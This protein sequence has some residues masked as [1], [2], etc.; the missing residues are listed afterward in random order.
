MFRGF[1]SYKL[2][3][4]SHK[5]TMA[6][7]VE[8]L[9]GLPLI[10]VQ[11][12]RASV[13]KKG[14]AFPPSAGDFRVACVQFVPTSIPTDFGLPQVYAVDDPPPDPRVGGL[15]RG[16]ANE[17]MRASDDPDMRRKVR[18]TDVEIGDA[19][20]HAQERLEGLMEMRDEPLKV[21]EHFGRLVRQQMVEGRLAEERR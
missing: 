15:L 20:A 10:A 14:G 12:G 1:P 9:H 7:Y 11:M 17:L 8:A 5:Q 18:R 4:E 21:S 2:D 3:G 6:V 16:L 13:I 19:R